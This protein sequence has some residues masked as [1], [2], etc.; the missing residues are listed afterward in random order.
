MAKGDINLHIGTTYSDDGFRKLNNALKTSG[1][2]MK[3]ASS[4]VN[5]VVNGLG[6]MDSKAGKVVGTMGS[7]LGSF[8]T[9][10]VAGLVIGGIT[11]AFQLVTN[12][13]NE[14]K[15]AVREMSEAIKNRLLAAMGDAEAK[16]AV[17][18]RS[19]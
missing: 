18:Q 19:F 9:M 2:N 13:I 17:V 10:G 14:A 6:N 3:K 7:L 5:Q 16:A 11:T 1:G 8:A 12:K 15:K 4:M